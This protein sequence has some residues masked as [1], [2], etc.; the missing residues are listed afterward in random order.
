MSDPGTDANRHMSEHPDVRLISRRPV[1][2]VSP[3][4]EDLLE[5]EL[6]VGDQRLVILGMTGKAANGKW[7]YAFAS[8][9]SP[10]GAIASRGEALARLVSHTLA[11]T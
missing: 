1:G 7:S 6:F 4:H 2:Y 9:R 5:H 11:P 8:G 3:F 10:E